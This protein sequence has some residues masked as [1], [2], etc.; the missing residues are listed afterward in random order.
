MYICQHQ[1]KTI[2]HNKKK[3]TT[4][5]LTVTA[6]S[7]RKLCSLSC[8]ML[9]IPAYLDYGSPKRTSFLVFIMQIIFSRFNAPE[10]DPKALQLQDKPLICQFM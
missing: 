1:I 5:Y 8:V 3:R 10:L 6:N 2:T 7:S 4:G 9:N